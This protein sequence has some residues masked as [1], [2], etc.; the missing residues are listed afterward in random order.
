MCQL[1]T[2]LSSPY[3]ALLIFISLM[4]CLYTG[5]ESHQLYGYQVALHW[6]PAKQESKTAN[7]WV[8]LSIF[9]VTNSPVPYR[10][11]WHVDG[12][13]SGQSKVGQQTQFI[14]GAQREWQSFTEGSCS[15]QHQQGRMWETISET[16]TVVHNTVALSKLPLY[17]RMG[18]FG[19]WAI[20]TEL[21]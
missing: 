15:G 2:P 3:I 5:T 12:G 17:C 9:S 21:V 8:S 4:T 1:L 16:V 6:T 10:H 13:D 11:S 20:W 14:L 7:K 18:K 19:E